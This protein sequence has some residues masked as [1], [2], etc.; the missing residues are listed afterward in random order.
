VTRR[1]NY[2]NE[3][4]T[5]L[6]DRTYDALLR[7]QALHGSESISSAAA[8]ALGTALLGVIGILPA[9]I[10]GVSADVSQLGPRQ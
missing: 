3:V 10:S 6:D 7:Y 5:R 1:A 4:K 2:R 9:D 8:R